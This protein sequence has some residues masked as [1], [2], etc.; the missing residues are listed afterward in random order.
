[1]R[2]VRRP[3]RRSEVHAT[4]VQDRLRGRPEPGAGK[5]DQRMADRQPQHPDRE[6]DTGEG[7]R[8]CDHDHDRL[9]PAH[10][11]AFTR[12]DMQ[13]PLPGGFLFTVADA[14][15]YARASLLFI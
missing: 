1:M 7:Q 5:A 10:A 11:L 8:P 15:A 9:S 6:R 14:R 13:K 3:Y 2:P 4:P 12:Y